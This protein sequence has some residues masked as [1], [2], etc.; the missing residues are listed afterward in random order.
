MNSRFLLHINNT[1]NKKPKGLLGIARVA[2]ES[3]KSPPRGH[4]DNLVICQGSAV[5]KLE[6][7]SIT[8]VGLLLEDKYY[9]SFPVPKHNLLKP[10][11]CL[12]HHQF[13]IQQL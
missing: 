9:F 12:M 6:N 13:N 2:V 7:T 5:Y 3:C 4:Y 8:D 1:L 11:C 10:T